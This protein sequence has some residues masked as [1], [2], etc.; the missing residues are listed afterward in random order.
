M[1]IALRFPP[2]S[3]GRPALY[4]LTAPPELPLNLRAARVSFTVA[5]SADRALACHLSNF[6]VREFCNASSVPLRQKYQT[7]PPASVMD[8][9]DVIWRTIS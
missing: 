9:F 2:E 7:P 5:Y 4:G 1:G 3:G 6:N 8:E